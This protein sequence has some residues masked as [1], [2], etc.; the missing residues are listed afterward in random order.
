MGFTKKTKYY[1]GVVYE[2]NLPTGWTCPSAKECLVKVDKDTGKMENK[3]NAYRCYAASAERFPGVRNSRWSNF[4]LS[5]I[6]IPELPKNCKAVRIHASGDFYSQNY[7]DKWLDYCKE[8]KDVE[9]W[10]YTKSL[11]FWIKRIKDIPNNLTLTASY[12]G[13]HD[14]LINEYKLKNAIVINE[15]K[16]DKPIDYNDDLARTKNISFYLLDNNKNIDKQQKK[17]F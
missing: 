10:G 5:K 11:N 7:F 13:K 4:E 17:L 14:K 2:W 9:F 3:S 15:Y 16:E 12:G 1:T 8:N 6:E